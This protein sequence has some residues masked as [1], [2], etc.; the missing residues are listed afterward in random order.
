M[1]LWYKFLYQIG[2]T[3]WEINP[4]RD[5][6]A[7]QIVNLF[8]R[9]EKGQKPPF[10][11]ALDLGCGS[12]IWSVELASRGWQVTGIDVIAKAV[13]KAHQRA[14]ATGVEV[15]FVHGDVTDLRTA[16]IVPGFQFFLDFECFNHLNKTQRMA[17]GRKV[18]A[19]AAPG[20]T[21]LMLVWAP[22]QRWPF[23]PGASRSDIEKAFTGWCITH[24]DKYAARSSLPSWLK[25]VDLRFFR[26]RRE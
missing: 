23:P 19:V 14:Q 24:E 20:A 21:I 2:L 22:G 16:G 26:L 1:S 11:P 25:N 9:E 12:G 7:M 8:E 18:T 13:R 10:G 6:A 15:K 5:P 3:P 17:V 4:T